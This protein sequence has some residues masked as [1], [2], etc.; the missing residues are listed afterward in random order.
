MGILYATAT[1]ADFKIKIGAYEWNVHKHVIASKLKFF[2]A[3][4]DSQFKVRS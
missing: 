2:K 3:V 1:P 4:V